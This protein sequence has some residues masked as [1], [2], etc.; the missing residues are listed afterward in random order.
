[1]SFYNL[2]NSMFL[3]YIR[4]IIW[5]KE[6]PIYVH[7]IINNTW[8]RFFLLE[9]R[10][11][12]FYWF[13]KKHEQNN[14]FRFYWLVLFDIKILVEL[15]LSNSDYLNLIIEGNLDTQVLKSQRINHLFSLGVFVFVFLSHICNVNFMSLKSN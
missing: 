7:L 6:L 9:P 14:Q 8:I 11:S 3:L 2:N 15:S 10:F 1:M 4:I 13:L 5:L 12:A